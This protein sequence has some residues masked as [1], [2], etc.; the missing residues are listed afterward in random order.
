MDDV[1]LFSECS[2]DDAKIIGEKAAY[3]AELYSKGFTIPPGFV[4]SG[5]LFVKFIEMTH[6]K[7]RI[8]EILI[9]SITTEQKAMQIQQILL[10]TEFPAD[11]ANF[12]YQSY[13]SLGGQQSHSEG[14]NEPYVALR[15]SSTSRFVEDAFFLN[16]KGKDRLINGLKSCWASL[17]NAKN[18]PLKRFKPSVIVQR[19]ANPVTSGVVYSINPITGNQNEMAILVTTGLSNVITLQQTIPSL[20]I[21]NKDDF[22]IKHSIIKEQ[23]V[24]YSLSLQKERTEKIQLQE[25]VKNILDEYILKEIAKL[26]T[27]VESRLNVPQ[28]VSFA[29]EKQVLLIGS[30]AIDRE[31]FKKRYADHYFTDEVLGIQRQTPTPDPEQSENQLFESSTANQ[32]SPVNDQTSSASQATQESLSQSTQ[33]GIRPQADIQPTQKLEEQSSFIQFQNP[34]KQEGSLNLNHDDVPVQ[35]DVEIGSTENSTPYF[36]HKEPSFE[37]HVEQREPSTNEQTSFQEQI[38]R[39]AEQNNQFFQD[40]QLENKE[41]VFQE[42]EKPVDPNADVDETILQHYNPEE[43]FLNNDSEDTGVTSSF[44][45]EMQQ[46]RPQ[47]Y[48]Q[49]KE[50]QQQRVEE[51]EHSFS[52]GQH[53]PEQTKERFVQEHIKTPSR[54]FHDIMFSASSLVANCDVAIITL[55]KNK[56]KSIFG[57]EAPEQFGRLLHELKMKMNIPFER[58]IIVIRKLRDDFLDFGRSLSPQEIEYCLNYTKQFLEAM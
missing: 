24:Q 43:Q 26:A 4:I 38:A 11:L 10:N 46:D 25:P 1:V 19:M 54:T 21:L 22:S 55:L 49:Q 48:F 28:R 23:T 45:N 27:K 51:S 13:M 56:Y 2:I 8:A 16:I 57:K 7:E 18:L 15:V 52:G 12:I 39:P 34:A 37:Q 30:K 36:E 20:Y 29:I 47:Q 44:S 6:L 17:F 58:E 9:S 14:L 40:D 41:P 50:S 35:S 5:N 32:Q 33:A 42:S 53:E 3:L 31:E